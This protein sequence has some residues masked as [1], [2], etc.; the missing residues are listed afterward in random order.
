MKIGLSLCDNYLLK[1]FFINIICSEFLKFNVL[2]DQKFVFSVLWCVM[3]RVC[4]E[5]FQVGYED[6]CINKLFL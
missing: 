4:V 6:I 2:K 5:L 1:G 3:L